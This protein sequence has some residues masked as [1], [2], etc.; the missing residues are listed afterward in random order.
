[1]NQNDRLLM[2]HRPNQLLTQ[3]RHFDKCTERTDMRQTWLEAAAAKRDTFWDSLQKCLDEIERKFK[4]MNIKLKRLREAL[5]QERHYM[6]AAH[7][8]KNGSE[9]KLTALNAAN[10]CADLVDVLLEDIIKDAENVR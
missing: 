10:R 6:N 7:M 4:G 5:N 8:Y 3:W 2:L 9:T 1:M